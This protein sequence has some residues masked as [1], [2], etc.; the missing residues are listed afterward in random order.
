MQTTRILSVVVLIYNK[1]PYLRACLDSILAQPC[2]REVVCVDDGSR[3]A[4]PDILR[5]YARTEERIRLVLHERNE[6]GHIALYDGLAQCSGDYLT[7]VDGDDMLIPGAMDA[8][9]AHAV[10]TGAD[11]VEFGFRV[12]PEGDCTP[13][14]AARDA[15][16]L[17]KPERL[18]VGQ[19]FC[20]L[21]LIDELLT[22]A[23]VGKLFSRALYRRAHAAMERL[24][25]G[26]MYPRTWYAVWLFCFFARRW[27]TVGIQGYHYFPGRGMTHHA[28]EGLAALRGNLGAQAACDSLRRTALE[29]HVLPEHEEELQLFLARCRAQSIIT[30]VERLPLEDTAAGWEL[31]TGT[32]GTDDVLHVLMQKYDG[33]NELLRQRLNMLA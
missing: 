29:H 30:W 33:D 9:C 11:V 7:I 20:R 5:E 12:T 18:L 15:Q 14:R 13:E 31:L 25:M 4:S 28:R 6:G 22:D 19:N 3:D 23:Y 16:A 17:N 10:T 8:L 1:A 24:P 26:D 27:S 21:C 32:W 2:V